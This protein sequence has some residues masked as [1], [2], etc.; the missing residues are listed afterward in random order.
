VSRD[1]EEGAARALQDQIRYYRERAAEYDDSAKPV[2]DSLEEQGEALRAALREFAP[3]GRVVEF[4]CGTGMF[5][6][7]LVPFAD[8]I[9]AV[10]AAPEMLELARVRI[11]DPKVRFVEAD[12]FS[13]TSDAAYDVAFFSFWLSHVPMTHF[14]RFWQIVGACLTP[15]GRVF[16]IDEGPQTP[17]RNDFVDEALGV[18]RRRLEDGSEHRAIKVLWDADQLEARLRGMGWE[19][20][21]HSTGAFYWGQGSRA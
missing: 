11:S 9:T 20:E 16:F 6:V 1:S 17:W 2:I 3:R 13:W 12:V 18:V 8:Q 5:T 14:D 21:C 10:D 19:V 7:D 15:E 4:A